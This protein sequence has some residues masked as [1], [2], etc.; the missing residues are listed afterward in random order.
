M[1]VYERSID[2]AA[3]PATVFAVMA[4]VERLEAERLKARSEGV[5]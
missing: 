5:R 3:P 1:T 4:D 2:I